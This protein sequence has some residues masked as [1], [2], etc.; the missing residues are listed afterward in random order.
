MFENIISILNDN[1]LTLIEMIGPAFGFFIIVL[2]SIIPVLPL[3][4]FIGLNTH[5]FGLLGGYL[6][7]YFA[8][9]LGSLISF[10]FFRHF[11]HNFIFK[12]AAERP[13]IMKLSEKLGRIKFSQ[14]VILLAIPFTPAFVVNIAAGLSK[15]DKKKYIKAVLL[16]KPIM[17]YFWGYIGYNFVEL[18]E[19]PTELINI[20]IALL[21]AYIVSRI[22]SHHYK[23]D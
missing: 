14:L 23:L 9:C 3:A 1:V 18:L 11:F 20:S 2:E 19:N 7:S 21:A 13:N 15:I 17:I 5:A 8:T 10:Y 4:L 16:G 22:V 12:K 6:I